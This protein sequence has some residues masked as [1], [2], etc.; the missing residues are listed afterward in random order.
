MERNNL[1]RRIRN[2]A[3]DIIIIGGGATGLGCAVDSASRGFKTLLLEQT[4]FSKGTSSRST[5]LIHG[6]VRYLQQGDI[7]MVF[8]ALQE[9]G[10]MFKNAPHL[11]TNQSFII[12]VYDWWGGPFYAI[13]LKV[14]DLMAG[15]LGLGPSKHLSR[16]E[17]IEALPTVEREGLKGGVIY[18]DGQFDDSRMA[19]TLALTA[20]DYGA[21]LLNYIKVTGLL[22]DTD[23][24]C[25]ITAA[26]QETGEVFKLSS[27]VVINATGVFADEVVQMDE[28]GKH[29]MVT[30]SQ[31]IHLVLGQE[32]LPGSH[33]IMVPQTSDG[34]VLFA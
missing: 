14:Y 18:Q 21:T 24:I 1:I 9:R 25:G 10:L 7:S 32:F 4:D 16:E 30:T 8:E 6:G 31:G 12:P 19:I 2:Q 29:G 22:K 3:W 17:A 34:R 20:A 27:K 23:L 28:P 33:A 13:G 15:K 26:D 5:K 11:V